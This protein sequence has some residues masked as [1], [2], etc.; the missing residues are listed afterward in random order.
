[1]KTVTLVAALALAGCDA[2]QPVRPSITTD[3][4]TVEVP[5]VV[6]VAA[7]ASAADVPEA[8]VSSMPVIDGA[9]P[10]RRAAGADADLSWIVPRYDKAR[11]KLIECSQ[12]PKEPSK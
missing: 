7:C 12:Q 4:R 5:P 1:M 3:V 8:F 10:K 11:Q 2:T 9:D 6:I